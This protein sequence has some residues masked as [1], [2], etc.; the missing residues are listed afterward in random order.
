MEQENATAVSGAVLTVFSTASGCGKTMLSINLAAAIAKLGFSVCLLETDTQFGDIAYALGIDPKE[1]LHT[2]QAAWVRDPGGFFI[3]D[4]VARVEKKGTVF[5]TLTA[6]KDIE[7]AYQIQPAHVK[8]VVKALRRKFDYIVVDTQA[9]FD[10]MNLMC[11]DQST[12]VLF[13]GIV[14]FLPT[15]KNMRI[16]MDTLTR[17][18]CDRE[19]IRCI[20]N[21]SGAR[22]R[23]PLSDVE[24]I[25][26]TSFQTHLPN[27]FKS[28]TK[29]FETNMPL[30]LS[31]NSSLSL[32]IQK[33]AKVFTG[34]EFGEQPK[35]EPKKEKKGFFARLFGK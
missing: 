26:G 19:R 5:F 20:L 34:E 31:G 25:L 7:D 1:N 11:I 8:H 10:Q 2:A 23:L 27:D 35:Q 28:V 29:S 21:R 3:E 13:L 6:P 18:G 15:V 17:I 30:V 14:D 16:G 32:E 22:T 24:G 12:L 4:Y 33:L 9:A